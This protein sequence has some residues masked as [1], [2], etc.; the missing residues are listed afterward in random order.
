M[1]MSKHHARF[2]EVAHRVHK[3]HVQS[4]LKL[5]RRNDGSFSG[6]RALLFERW[7]ECRHQH[8]SFADDD[9]AREARPPLPAV[10]FALAALSAPCKHQ[11][12]G[13]SDW[14]SPACKSCSSL[15]PGDSEH[16]AQLQKDARPQTRSGTTAES[17]RRVATSWYFI[18]AMLFLSGRMIVLGSVA[19]LL[20]H[21]ET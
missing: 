2:W 9:F 15:K 11:Q 21:C 20:K 18:L 12:V 19:V 1:R 10:A 14:F 17:P 13:I 4:S 6:G 7:Q 3:G 8:E 5:H 16:H